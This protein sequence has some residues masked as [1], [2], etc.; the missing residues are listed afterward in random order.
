[1]RKST[2]RGIRPGIFKVPGRAKP[3]QYIFAQTTMHPGED[4]GYYRSGWID[5]VGLYIQPSLDLCDGDPTQPPSAEC[6]MRTHEWRRMK[7]R[8]V[9][10]AAVP[11]WWQRWFRAHLDRNQIKLARQN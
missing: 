2:S 10:W 9:A 3:P 4:A 8:H 1:M 6:G 11:K 5:Y 7:Y